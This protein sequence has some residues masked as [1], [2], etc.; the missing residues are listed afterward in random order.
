MTSVCV[1]GT[2]APN[3][4]VD[5]ERESRAA[6]NPAARR[7]SDKGGRI[8]ARMRAKA[9]TGNDQSPRA[10]LS[11]DPPLEKRL[12]PQNRARSRADR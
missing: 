1:N 10:D 4:Q 11:A 9:A 6:L 5:D 2:L 7:V 12:T 8:P 3:P